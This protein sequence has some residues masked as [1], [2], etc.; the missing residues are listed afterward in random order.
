MLKIK[1]E[2][3]FRKAINLRKERHFKTKQ[4][5]GPVWTNSSNIEKYPEDITNNLK[6][7]TPVENT[8][9]VEIT[10]VIPKSQQQHCLKRK[11]DEN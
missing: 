6:A 8:L 1:T 7:D 11:K 2:I 5:I 10:G 3:N 9:N 4:E